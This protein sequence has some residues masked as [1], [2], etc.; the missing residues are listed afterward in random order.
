MK[1]TFEYDTCYTN[2]LN[3]KEYICIINRQKSGI[4]C[5]ENKQNN[6]IY[7]GSAVNLSDR[8]RKYFSNNSTNSNK[9]SYILNALYKHNYN[10]N[11]YILKYCSI[12]ELIK[13]EQ[14]YI[15]QLKPEYNILKYA[16]SSLGYRHTPEAIQK[17]KNKH[18]EKIYV[19]SKYDN[20]I[21][22]FDSYRDTMKYFKM[23]SST[24]NKYLKSGKFYKNTYIFFKEQKE[25]KDIVQ[26]KKFNLSNNIIELDKRYS[27]K[28]VILAFEIFQ[29]KV[30]NILKNEI[31][32]FPS[33]RKAAKNIN[34]N[35]TYLSK[36]IK[37]KG[38]YNGRGYIVTKQRLDG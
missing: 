7:V 30:E 36:C 15:S 24:I 19:I 29:Y 33:I 32:F 14:Y 26:N 12:A 17:M 13:Q 6:S 10:F 1:K 23:C 27:E 2:I 11:L 37:N 8:I 21:L 9:K 28:R 22:K 18:S 3:N 16:R 35:H 20:K 34:I 31:L 38:C 25:Y 5:W 4:Y